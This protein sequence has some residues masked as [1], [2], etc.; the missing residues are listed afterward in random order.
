[1]FLAC[2]RKEVYSEGN[3][4]PVQMGKSPLVGS[5]VSMEIDTLREPRDLG[6]KVNPK[7][8]WEP[9]EGTFASDSL[10]RN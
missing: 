10:G 9:T 2:S 8:T 3:G 1:M 7:G 5:L 4:S 6:R